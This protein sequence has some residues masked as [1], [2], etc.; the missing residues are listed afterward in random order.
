MTIA[1]SVAKTVEM[2]KSSETP[3]LLTPQQL[4]GRLQVPVSWVR[5][6]CRQRAQERDEDPLPFVPLGKYVRFRWADVEFWL[7]RQRR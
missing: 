1:H 7:A 3:I 6:K 4:A 5:E 2:C